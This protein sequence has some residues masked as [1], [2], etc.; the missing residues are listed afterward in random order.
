MN[1]SRIARSSLTLTLSLNRS[2]GLRHGALL[3]SDWK[4]AVPEAGAPPVS[5]AQGFNA[6]ILFRRI[7][8]QP[9][10]GCVLQPRVARA[11]RAT[12]GGRVEIARNPNGVVAVRRDGSA[13]TP[14]GLG[15]TALPSPRVARA[16]QPWAG[17]GMNPRHR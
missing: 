5:L 4:R 16:S 13:T 14:L 8:S 17:G 15:S 7:L 2:A 10:R 11:E 3:R 9:Q 12:L 1:P 6:R